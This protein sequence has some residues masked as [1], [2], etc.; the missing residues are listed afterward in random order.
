MK[1][2]SKV[3]RILD[4]SQA[5][6]IRR[7]DQLRTILDT[8]AAFGVTDKD[9]DKFPLHNLESNYNIASSLESAEEKDIEEAIDLCNVLNSINDESRWPFKRRLKD[10]TTKTLVDRVMTLYVTIT[11]I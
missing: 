11:G 8:L 1:K 10:K 9:F 4:D 3:K 2:P 7:Y 5:T 6:I